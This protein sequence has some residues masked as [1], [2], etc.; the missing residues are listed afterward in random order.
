MYSYKPKIIKLKRNK[1][2]K[3]S[4][5]QI[6]RIEQVIQEESD[7]KSEDD[8][9]L[10]RD[11]N[12]N[13]NWMMIV[14]VFVK[15]P[16]LLIVLLQH[17]L[18]IQGLF[19]Y[20]MLKQDY[21][22]NPQ[23][24]TIKI[25]LPN[26]K[27]FYELIPFRNP[28]IMLN[29]FVKFILTIFLNPNHLQ[30]N[31][32]VLQF[33]QENLQIIN[34]QILILIQIKIRVIKS[35]HSFQFMNQMQNFIIFL[36]FDKISKCILQLCQQHKNF[37][38]IIHFIEYIRLISRKI[39]FVRITSNKKQLS[40]VQIAFMQLYIDYLLDFHM[41]IFAWQILE[42]HQKSY[43]HLAHQKVQR[44][45][46][47]L[48]KYGHQKS[49]IGSEQYSNCRKF[50][51]T[52]RIFIILFILLSNSLIFPNFTSYQYTFYSNFIVYTYEN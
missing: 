22:F 6:S 48:K 44:R 49:L 27:L 33:L 15:Y 24:I 18:L 42:M 46:S 2:L 35:C 39:S 28:V 38:L 21:K 52:L 29:N 11:Q 36:I 3:L 13:P 14:L 4:Q 20:G 47:E 40:S 25:Y 19:N 7:N 10:F 34:S 51:R 43:Q 37:I 41:H 26:L 17:L 31:L 16:S 12:Q 1:E 50:K 9:Y 32:Q 45:T 23:I 30:F 8:N 5:F